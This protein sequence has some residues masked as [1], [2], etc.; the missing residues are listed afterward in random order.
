MT[1]CCKGLGIVRIRYRDGSPDDFG[2]CICAAGQSMRDDTNSGK[3][4]GYA[5]WQIWAAREKVLPERVFMLE[6][7]VDADELPVVEIPKQ[8]DAIAAAG[9]TRK[10]R[11]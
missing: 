11:L 2:V 1:A 9:R 3:H 5:R 8:V 7:L 6:E 4:T 10:P